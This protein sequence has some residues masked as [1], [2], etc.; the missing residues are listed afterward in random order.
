MVKA[1]IGRASL[2][3]FQ[4]MLMLTSGACIVPKLVTCDVNVTVAL[5]G[6]SDEKLSV[7]QFRVAD[8][9]RICE[10]RK[11]A[12]VR[13]QG[14]VDVGLRLYMTRYHKELGMKTCIK[15]RS[16]SKKEFTDDWERRDGIEFMRKFYGL[17]DSIQRYE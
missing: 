1:Q 17:S 6:R 15:K 5:L 13:K 8:V 4:G 16:R 12:M 9:M 11:R 7:E 2:V 3:T 14:I 10:K